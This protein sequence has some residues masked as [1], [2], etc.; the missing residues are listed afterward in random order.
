MPLARDAFSGADARFLRFAKHFEAQA[1]LQEEVEEIFKNH[2][3]HIRLRKNRERNLSFLVALMLS[4]GLKT[5]AAV[6]RLCVLGFGEDAQV[7]LRTNIN[8]LINLKY[9]LDAP[10][11]L[12]RASELLAS[13]YKNRQTFFRCGYNKTDMPIPCPVPEDK[14]AEYADAWGRTRIE[15]KAGRAKLK[16]FYY[17]KGYRYFSSMEHSEAFALN[18]YLEEWDEVGPRMRGES[19][20]GVSLALLWNYRTA[21]DILFQFCR[22]FVIERPDIRDALEVRE[23]QLCKIDSEAGL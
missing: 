22:Y 5:F 6:C 14:L 11:P 10:D 20:N 7:L 17:D 9:L 4:K 3:G 23:A 18:E 16:D 12:L 15:T 1:F 13:S 2:S 21:K 8:L 19:D